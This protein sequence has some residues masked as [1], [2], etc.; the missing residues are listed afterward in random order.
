MKDKQTLNVQ[1]MADSAPGGSTR[2]LFD[3]DPYACEF[4]A[5]V[6]TSTPANQAFEI[7]L[8][9]TLFFPESGG[10]PSDSGVIDSIPVIRVKELDGKI[11]HCLEKPVQE[12][13]RVHG[14]INWNHRF[15]HMQQH[16]GQHILS[17]T[18]IE[19]LNTETIGF[20]L[21]RQ[22]STIDLN[23][24]GIGD[25]ELSRVETR[26]N[27]IVML[28]KAIHIHYKR[29][30]DLDGLQLR[31]RPDVDGV[32]RIVEIDQFDWSGCCGTHVKTSGEIGLIKILRQEKYKEGSRITF[33]C[34]FRA[35]HYTQRSHETNR[36]LSKMLSV[37]EEELSS[38]VQ[39]MIMERKAQ[40][41][42]VKHYQRQLARS[43][44]EG[45]LSKASEHGSLM[46]IVECLDEYDPETL[47]L[48]ARQIVQEPDRLVVLCMRS[49][50]L[51]TVIARSK[52]VN[53]DIREAVE[54][55]CKLIHGRGGGGP[56]FGQINGAPVDKLE[57]VMNWGR[58]LQI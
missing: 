39:K 54:K 41:K 13:R 1:S 44:A 55:I 36:Q 27:E 40:I 45:L 3:E 12:G 15:D 9:Q 49:E 29:P 38:A 43:A 26:A 34:G 7:T 32:L 30:E 6:V 17:Q 24:S 8:N 23:C 50:S 10:Q 56:D 28:N 31:K 21:G 14:R 5:T 52:N 4:E 57:H 47:L 53:W 48:I 33:V 25:E 51:F 11:I 42:A 18:F 46:K 19:L 58:F 35:L 16:T 20:H 37:G 22:I 2:R